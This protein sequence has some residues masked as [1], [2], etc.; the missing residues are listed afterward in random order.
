[1]KLTLTKN[2]FLTGINLVSR[3]AQKSVNL[4][5]LQDIL[6]ETTDNI[7]KIS[8]TNL[9]VGITFWA[10]AKVEKEGRAAVPSNIL[11]NFIASVS[12]NKIELRL[13][14]D[15]LNIKS[16]DGS[17]KILGHKADEYPIIPVLKDILCKV[18]AR[19][20]AFAISQVVDFTS[21]SQMRP[22]LS[23]VYLKFSPQE[24]VAA[25]SDSFRLAEKTIKSSPQELK[26]EKVV[27]LPKTA[28]RE[29]ANIF[30]N[31]NEM[32][33]VYLSENQIM[34]QLAS[35]ELSSPKVQIASQLIEGVYPDYKQIIPKEF[36]TQA[37][38]NRETL[39]N[40][41]KAVGIFS[42][43]G[44]EV[45]MELDPKAQAARLFASS[46]EV[47]ENEVMMPVKIQGGAFSIS[48]NHRF[49]SEGLNKFKGPDISFSFSSP[50]GP[51]ILRSPEDDS[52]FYI[53]MPLK[54]K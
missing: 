28:A 38:F 52:Y 6:L 37:V 21:L 25:A 51:A 46:S 1:M 42:G 23:G 40:K 31:N 7:L 14:G 10:L 50:E 41:L 49:L 11:S 54:Q 8:A 20:L 29:A 43:R 4:P 48:F 3:L 5:I 35:Q 32:I 53:L 16:Q 26:K 22:E 39:I 18:D 27:L 24:I 2:E 17:A 47:G 19:S 44:L 13:E 12:G 30:Q 36:K 45:K 9:E 34:F 33:G 15:V